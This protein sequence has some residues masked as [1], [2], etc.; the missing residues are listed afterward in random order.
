[1]RKPKLADATLEEIE[2]N[3]KL[4]AR[5]IFDKWVKV[6]NFSS[7]TRWDAL[8]AVA[9]Q[10]YELMCSVMFELREKTE[11]L[12]KIADAFEIINDINS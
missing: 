6:E 3:E 11:K 1:M 5:Q 10:D 4:T 7:F 9:L 2:A 8:K 12:N